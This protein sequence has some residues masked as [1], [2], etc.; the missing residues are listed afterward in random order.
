MSIVINAPDALRKS[1]EAASQGRNTV[2]YTAKGQPSLMYVQP[3]V[4]LQDIDPALGTGAHPAFIIDG[5][6]RDERLYGL[7]IGADLNGELISQPGR[8]PRHTFNHDEFV[9][10]CRANGPGHHLMTNADWNLLGLLVWADANRDVR[11]NTAS[12]RS[13]SHPAEFGVSEAGRALD[14]GGGERTLT[15]SGPVAWR[16]THTPFG[17]SDL[18]GNVWEWS[19]G[20]RVVD[21]EIQ[22]IPDNGAAVN[23]ADL[24]AT[25]TLWQAISAVDGSF[26]APGHADSVKYATSGTAAGT[27]VGSSGG[28]FESLTAHS[29]D[30]EALRKLQIYGLY[31]Q[32]ADLL[33][34]GW[35]VTLTGERV[36]FRGGGWT[37]G[38]RAGLRAVS[39]NSGRGDRSAAFGARPAF[40]PWGV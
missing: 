11:G 30:T 32:A 20:A 17:M 35:W 13:H 36:P 3:K 34:D 21:G 29:V 23:D 28:A 6:E 24:S 37:N 22:V 15:G 18:T 26:V 33:G 27:I 25:S 4:L 9:T 2:I 40:D 38:A 31:P 1:V 10:L 14:Q 16:H 7:H 12:G 39:L 8:A 5:V 19:P